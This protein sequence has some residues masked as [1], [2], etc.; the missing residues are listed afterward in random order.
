MLTRKTKSV[1]L[2]MQHLSGRVLIIMIVII[3]L[4]LRVLIK[5]I[6]YLSLRVL[7]IIII[8]MVVVMLHR[9][10]FQKQAFISDFFWPQVWRNYGDGYAGVSPEIS[11]EY[12]V[13][14]TVI[15][16]YQWHDRNG[17]CSKSCGGGEILPLFIKCFVTILRL[18]LHG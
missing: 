18:Y 1:I 2:I 17:A 12:Y 9:T 10:P 15:S 6:L 11:Y 4:S 16:D 14:E 8:S 7:I 3:H 13:S 5:M